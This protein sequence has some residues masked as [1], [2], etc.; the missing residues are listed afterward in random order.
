MY[1]VLSVGGPAGHKARLSQLF[2]HW[3]ACKNISISWLKLVT[4]GTNYAN[5]DQLHDLRESFRFTYLNSLAF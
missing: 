5:R 2:R 3:P 4:S 1:G